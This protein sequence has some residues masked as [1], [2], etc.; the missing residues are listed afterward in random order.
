MK[1]INR[2]FYSK[3][4]SSVLSI[5]FGVSIVC[6]LFACT[7]DSCVHSYVG[8]KVSEMNKVFRSGDKCVKYVEKSVEC[9]KNK[10]KVDF[11]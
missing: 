5:L 1:S 4:S 6:I 11:A 9:D 3:H 2:I 10:K 7:E 8:P